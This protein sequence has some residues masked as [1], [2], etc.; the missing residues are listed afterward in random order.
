MGNKNAE[1]YMLIPNPKTKFRKSIPMK[2]IKKNS[3][4]SFF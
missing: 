1:L 2:V 3:K 4:K